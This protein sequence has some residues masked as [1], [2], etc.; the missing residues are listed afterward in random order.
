[1]QKVQFLL[2]Q[3]VAAVI[4]YLSFAKYQE[5][6]VSPAGFLNDTFQ[7]QIPVVIDYSEDED[8]DENE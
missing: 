5:E 4:F 2:Q 6:F 1:M 3:D 7:D 8:E